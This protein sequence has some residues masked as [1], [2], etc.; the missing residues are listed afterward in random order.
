M[1]AMTMVEKVGPCPRAC[2][3]R[4][5]SIDLRRETSPDPAARNS[6]RRSKSINREQHS[7]GNVTCVL[8]CVLF[9][10]SDLLVRYVV[11]IRAWGVR[12]VQRPLMRLARAVFPTVE[13]W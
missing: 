11:I 1:R 3:S 7:T 2:S 9:L 12:W 13:Q 5:G 10:T 8:F 6:H 4:G